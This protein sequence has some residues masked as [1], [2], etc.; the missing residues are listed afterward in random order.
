[1]TGKTNVRRCSKNRRSSK[2][3]THGECAGG[4]QVGV[5]AGVNAVEVVGG[6]VDGLQCTA[7]ESVSTQILVVTH[8]L[9][10]RRFL[11]RRAFIN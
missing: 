1:M 4:G 11:S 10:I 9:V 8:N 7:I 2:C 3:D 5:V 6:G